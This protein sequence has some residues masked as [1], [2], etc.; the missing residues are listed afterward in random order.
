MEDP[1]PSFGA[2]RIVTAPIPFWAGESAIADVDLV[3]V[4]V[5]AEGEGEE[6]IPKTVV[7]AIVSNGQLVT[8]VN[9]KKKISKA[10]YQNYGPSQLWRVTGLQLFTC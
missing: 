1:S 6:S 4:V 5:E 9:K 7:T 8:A 3:E 10:K 2:G